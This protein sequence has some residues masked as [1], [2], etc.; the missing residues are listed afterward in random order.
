MATCAV[1]RCCQRSTDDRRLCM[2][3]GDSERAVAKFFEI[4]NLGTN[5]V[6]YTL[7]FGD[8]GI[9]LKRSVAYTAPIITD[10]NGV[11]N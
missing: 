11:Y 1:V 8:I 6:G 9:S 10:M 2:A 7:I 5:P 4:K 3:F